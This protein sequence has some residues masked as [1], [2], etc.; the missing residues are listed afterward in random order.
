[1]RDLVGTPE[2][3]LNV[4]GEVQRLKGEELTG[5]GLAEADSQQE[6]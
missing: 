2:I 1:M 6:D 5:E 3:I 4:L